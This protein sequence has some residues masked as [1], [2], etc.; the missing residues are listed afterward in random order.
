MFIKKLAALLLAVT[1]AV[2]VSGIALADNPVVTRREAS[3]ADCDI[4]A[5]NKVYATTA[6][7]EVGTNRSCSAGLGATYYYVDPL[8]SAAYYVNSETLPTGS[9]RRSGSGQYGYH[10]DFTAPNNCR[11]VKVVSQCVVEYSGQRWTSTLTTV[12]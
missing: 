10:I 8:T 3:L 11:S 4:V 9:I 1:L 12:R 2:G 7:A 5:T 6:Q